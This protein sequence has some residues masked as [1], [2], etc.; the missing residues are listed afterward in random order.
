[1]IHEVFFCVRLIELSTCHL[2][3]LTFVDNLQ[4]ALGVVII[5]GIDRGQSNS[6]S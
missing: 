1:M 2:D 4:H 6:L 3:A 5:P